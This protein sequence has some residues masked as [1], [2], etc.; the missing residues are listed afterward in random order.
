VTTKNKFI[1]GSFRHI[2]YTEK[3]RKRWV[4]DKEYIANDSGMDSVAFRLVK[5]KGRKHG[6]D[7]K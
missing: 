3:E 1:S 4:S 6:T 7:K 2:F 5:V